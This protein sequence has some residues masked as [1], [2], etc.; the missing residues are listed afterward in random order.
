MDAIKEEK[1]NWIT[2]IKEKMAPVAHNQPQTHWLDTIKDM[3]KE[4][5]APITQPQTN[6]WMD[7]TMALHE[8][9]APIE[10][11]AQEHQMAWGQVPDMMKAMMGAGASVPR[12]FGSVDTVRPVEERLTVGEWGRQ[13]TQRSDAPVYNTPAEV[14]ELYT[15]KPPANVRGEPPITVNTRAAFKP[16][17]NVVLPANPEGERGARSGAP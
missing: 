7:N 5:L 9:M 16:P 13:F 15:M 11:T 14:G 1:M 8:R 12:G 6:N 4:K 17:V 2:T 10:E 3:M